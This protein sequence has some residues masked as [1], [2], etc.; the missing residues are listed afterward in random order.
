MSQLDLS[1]L[2]QKQPWRHSIW[3]VQSWLLLLMSSVFTKKFQIITRY[4][5]QSKK[6]GKNNR[7]SEGG[8]VDA[9]WVKFYCTIATRSIIG[10]KIFYTWRS[11]NMGAWNCQGLEKCI[12]IR[13]SVMIFHSIFR[14]LPNFRRFLERNEQRFS[15]RLLGLF[16]SI[17]HPKRVYVTKVLDLFAR[18]LFIITKIAGI[19][20]QAT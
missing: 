14:K 6:V 7:R 10:L 13:L 15:G 17:F 5:A 1:R 19:S 8:D 9:L 12:I 2:K 20:S 18:I 16:I 3:H 4:F 11:N